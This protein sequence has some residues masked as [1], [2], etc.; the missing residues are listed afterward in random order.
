MSER[1]IDFAKQTVPEPGTSTRPPRVALIREAVV[2][3]G[4]GT[5]IYSCEHCGFEWRV[6]LSLGVEGP[7]TLRDAELF[8]P[9]P[10]GGIRCPAWP[11]KSG[12]TAEERARF[13]HMTACTG[14]MSH[15]RFAADEE[16]EPRLIPDDAPRFVLDA[17]YEHGTLVVPEPAII[18][19]RR[20]HSDRDEA[21]GG[22]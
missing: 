8:V 18:A 10:F 11:I 17:W 3:L 6:W 2:T 4:W 21:N 15:V 20:F 22:E 7:P 5:M 13:Q 19:A 14:S 16:F 12:A 1:L 9:A